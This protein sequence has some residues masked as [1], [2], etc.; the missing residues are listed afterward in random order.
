MAD[1]IV[2]PASDFESDQSM[3][4][5][6]ARDYAD[7]FP[8]HD[9]PDSPGSV[10]D[11]NRDILAAILKCVPACID[12]ADFKRLS[13][14]LPHPEPVQDSTRTVQEAIEVRNVYV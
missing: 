7:Q 4:P 8:Y 9:D 2:P 11:E 3:D 6:E 1:P 13:D 12:E 5:D 10:N 14:V